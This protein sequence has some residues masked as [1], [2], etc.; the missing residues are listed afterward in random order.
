[1]EDYARE[2]TERLNWVIES[3]MLSDEEFVR[4]CDVTRAWAEAEVKVVSA[5][6][7]LLQ[8]LITEISRIFNNHFIK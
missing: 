6:F 3:A 4:R 7:G 1:M 2:I 5:K 8:Q